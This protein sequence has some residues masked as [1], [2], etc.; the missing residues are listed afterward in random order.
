VTYRK[1]LLKGDVREWSCFAGTALQET[2]ETYPAIRDACAKS[3]TH[4]VAMLR[5]MID[6][7]LRENPVSGLQSESL[8]V[9]ILAV[10]Q[11]AFVMAKARQD[12]M[13]AVDSLDH[14]RRYLELLFNQKRKR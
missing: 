4:H 8:A 9:H 1:E 10:I 13:A 3:I 5:A 2:H 11:G 14:I 7:V 12:R 6:D